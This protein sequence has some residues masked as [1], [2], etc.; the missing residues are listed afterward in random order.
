MDR[1]GLISVLSDRL[2]RAV[3]EPIADATATAVERVLARFE[4][5]AELALGTRDSE[6]VELRKRVTERAAAARGETEIADR[7]AEVAD[8]VAELFLD[9]ARGPQPLTK[10]HKVRQLVDEYRKA[11]S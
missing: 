10:A 9:G 11:R 7:L 6:L 1:S 5:R 3:A 2:V 8:E 4:A